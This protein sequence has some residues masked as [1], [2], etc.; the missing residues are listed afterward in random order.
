MLGV[1]AVVIQSMLA[2]ICDNEGSLLL[3]LRSSHRS[4]VEQ[5]YL[6][7]VHAKKLMQVLWYRAGHSNTPTFTIL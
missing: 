5:F 3:H 1:S 4:E 6:V 7:A 2:T